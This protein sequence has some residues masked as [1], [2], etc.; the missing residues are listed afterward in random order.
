VNKAA[1]VATARL[2]DEI[3]KMAGSTSGAAVADQA[4]GASALLISDHYLASQAEADQ[5]AK[6]QFNVQTD[7]F[8]T[9]EA[10]AIGNP[11]LAAGFVV[12]VTKV[13]RRLSGLYYIAAASHVIKREGYSTHLSLQRNA[14]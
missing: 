4:Y 13:G 1:I 14:I 6:A 7:G 12:E 11:D 3:T 10:T 9:G 5:I 8:I 2:G